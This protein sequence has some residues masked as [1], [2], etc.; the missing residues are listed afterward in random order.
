M[1]VLPAPDAPTPS[2]PTLPVLAWR[3]LVTGLAAGG[4]VG[5]LR[6]SHDHVAARTALW[7][8]GWHVS[9]WL[10]PFWFG[11][12]VAL[13][14]GLR[15][16]VRVEP[17]I[18]GSGIPQTELA[19]K[20]RLTFRWWRVLLAKFAGSWLALFGG[21]ALGREGPSIQMGGAV[22]AGFDALWRPGGEE[23]LLTENPYVVAGA[24][25]GLAAAFGAPV[26]GVLFAFEEMRCPRVPSLIVIAC[27][28]AIGAHIMVFGVFGMGR[29]LPFA[30]FVTPALA[31]FWIV[32]AQGLFFGVLGVMYNHTLLWLHD[33][34]ARQT[35]I[36]DHWR[37]RRFCSRGWPRFSCRCSWEAART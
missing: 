28:A 2:S 36:P 29:I 19:L 17:M 30:S 23:R 3:G 13:A 12:L 37:A 1:P 33:V 20:G 22:G 27:T 18:S 6:L 31:D 4:V 7:L 9:L 25:A 5:L 24:V 16:I 35:L 21:L 11:V 8:D 26:A 14:W 34:E 10:V 15:W 32:A